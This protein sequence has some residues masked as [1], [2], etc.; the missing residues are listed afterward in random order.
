MLDF[1]NIIRH[2]LFNGLPMKKR[3]TI[4]LAAVTN[5]YCTTLNSQAQPYLDSAQ[6]LLN[7]HQ[8]QL[9]LESAATAQS[10]DAKNYRGY[11][12]QAQAYQQLK[13]INGAD[14]EYRQA[15]ALAPLDYQ[16]QAD[17]AGFLCTNNNFALAKNY[18]LS[19]LQVAVKNK[20]ATPNLFI[21]YGDCLTAHNQLELATTSYLEALKS[22]SAPLSAYTGI[23]YAYL[24]ENN[25]GKAYYYISLYRGNETAD[26]LNIKIMSVQR[27]LMAQNLSLSPEN[28]KNLRLSLKKYQDQLQQINSLSTGSYFNRSLVL[29]QPEIPAENRQV[30]STKIKPA[31]STATTVATVTKSPATQAV[32]TAY[33]PLLPRIKTSPAGRKYV[34]VIKGDTL[35]NLALRSNNSAEKL[36]TL[37]KMSDNNVKLGQVVYLD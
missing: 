17:Y 34:T 19:A 26:T 2:Y 14:K 23:S 30:V 4:L 6:Q 1:G 35:F 3:L 15:L 11:Y 24:L 36:R 16:L 33:P 29:A 32:T 21:N 13:N 37:N 10:I 31:N 22:E 12:L 9:A 27:L 7:K 25:P 8:Y 5:Y 18:Y 20:I 28:K